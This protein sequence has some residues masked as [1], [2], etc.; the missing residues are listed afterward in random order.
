MSYWPKFVIFRRAK[1]V[2]PT[3][4]ND[5]VRT[6]AALVNRPDLTVIIPVYNEARTIAN[7]LDAVH[8]S[9]YSMQIL[10]IDDGSTDDT[11]GAIDRWIDRTD[12]DAEVIRHPT[13]CGKGTAI[14]T[15]LARATGVVTIIQDA[16]LEYDVA[17]YP[18]IVEPILTGKVDVVYGSRYLRPD[19]SLP[20][21]PNRVCVHLLNLMV[22]VLYGLKITDEATGYK[23]FRTDILRRM[24]LRCERFEFCP[25]V[26][27][28]VG[29]MGLEIREVPIRYRPR[30]HR[31][32]KKIRWPD[33][34]EAVATLCR[35]RVARFRPG[36]LS[37][38]HEATPGEAILG[39]EEFS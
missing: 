39:I 31:D 29:R 16:D 10:V 37:P 24:D 20:W 21:T 11:P 19:N 2:K 34:L 22:R 7:V 38:H 33:G 35:W 25:E 15:G 6:G 4:L 12:A 32:G 36:S 30:Y 26:T 23:A 14:R 27:A 18:R 28:K 9:P 17:D 5:Y 8:S 3:V 13:N 1:Y